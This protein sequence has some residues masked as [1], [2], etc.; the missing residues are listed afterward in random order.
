MKIKAPAKINLFLNVGEERKDSFHEVFSL[1][2]KVSLFDKIDI[3]ANESITVQA[4]DWLAGQENLVYKAAKELKEKTK[5]TRGCKIILQK[6]IPPGRGLGGGSSDCAAVLKA[7]NKMWNLNLETEELEK[8]GKKLGSDV[9]FFLHPGGCT[10]SGRGEKV[11]PLESTVRDRNNIVVIDPDIH[12]STER[13]YQRY[14]G[15]S[16]TD[17]KEKNRII[18]KYKE[19]KWNEILRND[20]EDTVFKEYPVLRDLKN[21]LKNWGAWPLLS[22]SGSCVFA[23]TDKKKLA[24]SI[25]DIVKRDFGYKT[26]IVKEYFGE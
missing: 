3:E 24:E 20:L 23:V 14:S 21:R 7:L 10:S 13:I 22:G 5:V 17:E 15:G 25:A 4:P 2:I 16:L 1:M 6:N 12:I 18:Q 8:I 9:N 11:K 26:W 19:N